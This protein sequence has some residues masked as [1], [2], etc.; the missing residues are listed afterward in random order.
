M[1]KQIVIV[2]IIAFL[3]TQIIGCWDRTEVEDLAIVSAVGIDILKI[4][5]KKK[6][7]V[8]IQ[9]A[10]PQ[11]IGKKDGGGGGSSVTPVWI[12]SS[13]G[14]TIDDALRN[15]STRASRRVFL[16][17]SKLIVLGDE[18]ARQGVKQIIDVLQR[19]REIR[20]RDWLVVFQGE[21]R[22]LLNIRPSLESLPS[23]E[24]AGLFINS[25]PEVS[26]SYVITIKDFANTMIS[27]G[28]DPIAG[29]IKV[30]KL[31]KKELPEDELLYKG[32]PEYERLQGAAVFRSDKLVGYLEDNETMG[33]LW[34][35]GYMRRGVMSLSENGVPD[36]SIQITNGTSQVKPYLNNGKITVRIK[37][38]AEGNISE[39]R[40]THKIAQQMPMLEKEFAAKI[41]EQIRMVLKK[42]QTD[43]KADIFGFGEYVHRKYK[44][45]WHEKYEK[46][47]GEKYFPKI[48]VLIDV[49]AK[50]RGTG[51]I[52]DSIE[53]K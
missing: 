39:H 34:V 46:E 32:K 40:S 37:I 48:K 49:K 53:P 27:S 12:E 45:E 26:K 6:W 52:V 5:D 44:K 25:M 24:I 38:S 13:V 4:H 35:N 47:W 10:R 18:A 31:A 43:Y 22:D 21:A 50:I 15:F 41:E 14:D 29:R 2:I 8:S 42:A 3:S 30:Y 19:N 9:V 33:L 1:K 11:A 28:A 23:N 16:A 7:Q 51:M 17:H 36:M 20:L